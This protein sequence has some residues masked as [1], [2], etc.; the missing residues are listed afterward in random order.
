MFLIDAFL[1][2]KICEN[3]PTML[4]AVVNWSRLRNNLLLAYSDFGTPGPIHI[5]LGAD[6]FSRLLFNDVVHGAPGEPDDV[7]IFFGHW[8]L[9]LILLGY[10]KT[11]F[12]KCGKLKQ[13]P[14]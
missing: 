4:V 6:I 9:L 3:L 14:R 1:L 5:L 13:F 8:L 2:P 12:R 7:K 10:W 11:L